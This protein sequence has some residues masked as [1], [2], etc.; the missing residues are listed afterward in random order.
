MKQKGFIKFTFPTVLILIEVAIGYLVLMNKTQ[1]TI[2]KL[3]SKSPISQNQ[4]S[5]N[6]TVLY[7]PTPS[8]FGCNPYSGVYK[9]HQGKVI[10]DYEQ[11]RVLYDQLLKGCYTKTKAPQIIDFSK[12]TMLAVFAGNSCEGTKIKVKE[13]SIV[14]NK[15]IVSSIKTIGGCSLPS[16]SF[17]FTLI[18]I[19]K[20]DFPVEFLFESTQ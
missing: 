2:P 17:P 10:Q 4:I 16:F 3:K 20:S 1:P 7:P 19:D 18:S 13:A 9:T 15:I 14:G 11:W 6:F 12:K 5:P 8:S